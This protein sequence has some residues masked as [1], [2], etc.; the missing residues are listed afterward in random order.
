MSEFNE[1]KTLLQKKDALELEKLKEVINQEDYYLLVDLLTELAEEENLE[2]IVI[3]FRLLD[4]ELSLEVFEQLS[5]DMQEKLI[6]SF[7]DEKANEIVTG[8]EPDDR[9]RLMD[10]LPAKVTKTLLNKLAPEEREKT[11]TLLGYPPETAGRIMTPE[12]VRLRAEM[13]AEQALE[14]IRNQRQ[15]AETIY[16]LY[17]TDDKRKLLGV[18]SLGDLVTAE[19]TAKIANI[20]NEN[21]IKV[22][23]ETD[24]EEVAKVLKDRDLLA[25]PVVDKEDRLVG[26]VTVDDAMDILEEETT[27]DIFAKAGLTTLTTQETG[28]SERLVSG[29]IWQAW[30]VRIPFLI[31][32]LIGGMLAGAVIDAYEATLEAI[33]AVAIFI[34]VIMDMGGNVGTQSSTIFTRAFVLGHINVRRFGKHLSREVLIGFSMGALMGTAAGIIASTWQQDPS[35]GWAVGISLCLTMTIATFLGYLIPFILVRMGFDQAAGSDPFITSI[36]DITGLFI[37]FTSVTIFLGHML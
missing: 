14:K 13:T 33:A 35:F 16:V 11:A 10:E 23:T 8:M 24:Q 30:K 2:D 21:V 3:L 34:P 25:V 15:R 37:Y 6:Q 36:K 27:E 9:A 19:K 5:L 31:I 32:T 7:T 4:K 17:V 22:N 18:L 28:R 29:P 12:Y 1:I 20:M 26:I